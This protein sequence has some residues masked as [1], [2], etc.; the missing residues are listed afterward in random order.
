[1]NSANGSPLLSVVVVAFNDGVFLERC[2][3][4]LER[5]TLR[6]GVEI[7]VVKPWDAPVDAEEVLKRRFQ[8]VRWVRDSHGYAVPQLRCLGITHSRGDII[9]FLE[10]DCIAGETWC[11]AVVEAHRG[12]CVA[13]GGAVAPGGYMKL[14]DWAMY[15]FEYAPFLPPVPKRATH[16]L[17]GTNVSYKRTALFEL[18]R[19]KTE[20][21]IHAGGY[22][23]YEF[24]V[25]GALWRAGRRMEID[26]ALVV[27]NV[28]SWEFPK[29]LRSRFHHGR[30]FAAIRSRRGSLGARLLL[31]VVSTALPPIQVA[32]IVRGV[33]A[34]KR[35]V[36]KMGMALLWIILL[37]ISWSIGEFTGYLRGPG[38]SLAQWR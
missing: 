36:E 12:D 16:V 14:L 27:Q 2:L 19:G 37:S 31:L 15:F 9:A 10:D 5:Q 22:G 8:T 20:Y 35:H 28:N 29:A 33:I 6:E 38:R 4:S 1:M 30:G 18:M 25:H 13:A 11:A 34:R 7:I 21:D 24:F 32:R 23:F 26:P 3:T 17:P